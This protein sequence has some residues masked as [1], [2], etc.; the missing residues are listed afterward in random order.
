VMDRGG[1][2][3]H[4]ADSCTGI[5]LLDRGIATEVRDML[6]QGRL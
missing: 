1:P 3:T 6:A 2:S 5:A 4:P